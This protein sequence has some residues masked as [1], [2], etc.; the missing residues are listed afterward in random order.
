VAL[1]GDAEAEG[2]D[3]RKHILFHRWIVGKLLPADERNF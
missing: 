2:D 3:E 1:D